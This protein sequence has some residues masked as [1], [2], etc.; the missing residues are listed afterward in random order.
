[1]RERWGG[2]KCSSKEER[3]GWEVVSVSEK[4]WA[5]VSGR[6]YNQDQFSIPTCILN[7]CENQAMTQMVVKAIF[8]NGST[9]G[10]DIFLPMVLVEQW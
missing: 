6:L 4:E 1:M 3:G 7:Q 8:I 9:T 5:R 2:R 10:G